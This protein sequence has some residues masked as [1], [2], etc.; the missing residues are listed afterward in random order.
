MSRILRE[1]ELVVGQ[2]V[3][4]RLVTLA[5]CT[6]R[7]LAWLQDPE[8]HRFLETRWTEQS[9]ETIRAFVRSA[10]ESP[11]SYLLAIVLLVTGEHIGNIK[12]GPIQP[13][14]Q[15]ADLSYFIGERT[16]W[17][18]GYATEAIALA[19]GI[20][21]CRL[22]LHRVQAG[23]YS[24]NP[25]SGR[26]LERVGFRPEGVFRQK[27]RIDGGWQ[28]HI[29]YGLLREEWVGEKHRMSHDG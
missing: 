6:P 19:V 27:L 28:D 17:G 20:A 9:M 25:A 14:H 3:G 16:K 24:G 2:A 26:A 7:Y 10:G 29:V 11:D 13:R 23:I 18:R 22:G 1:D 5:D 21:F 12:I 15:Y 4:L 8:V